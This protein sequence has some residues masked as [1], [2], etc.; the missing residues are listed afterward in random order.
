MGDSRD[1]YMIVR[2]SIIWLI[3]FDIIFMTAVCVG[4]AIQCS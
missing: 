3:M 4:W 1:L 2:N